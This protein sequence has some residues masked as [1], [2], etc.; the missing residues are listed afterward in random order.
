MHWPS[1]RAIREGASTELLS[2]R[3]H[4]RFEEKNGAYLSSRKQ[5]VVTLA[6]CGE[7]FLGAFETLKVDVSKFGDLF[8]DVMTH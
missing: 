6:K 4:D 1:A 8:V 3:L 2:R 7:M 5:R